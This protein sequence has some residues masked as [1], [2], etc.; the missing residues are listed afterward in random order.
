M[1]LTPREQEAAQ[2]IILKI[3]PAL[4]SH[5]LT[6]LGLLAGALHIA[7]PAVLVQGL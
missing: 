1:D 6:V 2:S 5:G 3:W 4:K 7:Q